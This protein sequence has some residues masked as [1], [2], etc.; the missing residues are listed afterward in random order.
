MLVERLRWQ[1][2][3]G[4][5][6]GETFSSAD[7]VL[8]FGSADRIEAAA[9][10]AALAERFPRALLLGCSTAAGILDGFRDETGLVGVACRLQ[11]SH[12]RLVEADVPSASCSAEAG[13]QLGEALRGEA[14]AGVFVL[15]DGV[16]VNGSAITSAIA[17]ALG[18]SVP[19]TGGLAADGAKFVRTTVGA[20]QTAR[21]GRAAALGFYGK[22]IRM[23]HAS[24]G[25][26]DPFG[27]RRRITRADGC[28]LAELDG[29]AALSL[30]EKYL[31]QE[32]AGLPGT[33]LFF[34][35][36]IWDPEDPSQTRVR[37][38]LSIDPSAGTMTFAG[39]IPQGWGAQLMRGSF[40][41][42]VDHAGRAGTLAHASLNRPTG[43]Q[44][45]ALLVSCVGRH[46]LLGQR[47]DEE[48]HAVAEALGPDVTQVG[49]YSHGEIAPNAVCREAILQ[50]QTMVVT[51][52]AEVP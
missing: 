22:A 3:C 42:L 41:R 52:L 47:T 51:L 15:S 1:A 38:V 4:W 17:A 46:M 10:P 7:F 50:N 25:G 30:Y 8:Y 28:T 5:R 14:L 36:L 39:D 40:D 27:P 32:A 31:G 12:V 26:W 18:K 20:G 13:R 24:G 45:L 34:P 6:G 35:L 33:A 48:L 37:T 16:H 19:V 23:G 43:S 49:F 44:A 9:A 21:S 11:D 29:K 2:Q